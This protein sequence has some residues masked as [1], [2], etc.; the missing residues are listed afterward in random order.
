MSNFSRLLGLYIIILSFL[1]INAPNFFFIPSSALAKPLTS[2]SQECNL[3]QESF[4][5]EF[6]DYPIE[7]Q[8]WALLNISVKYR[9]K[10]TREIN[11]DIYPDF[12]PIAKR[13]EQFLVE[14]PNE[15]D[16][17]EV[18]NRNLAQM[19]LNE[20]SD[21]T[22]IRIYINVNHTLNERYTRH[23]EITLTRPGSCPLTHS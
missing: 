21:L 23:S 10:N 4:G 2:I 16:Y 13:I 7:H 8:G 20:Y 1:G 14:Y 17:W 9:L 11:P 19:L 5:F 15:T 12:V 22:S 18:V 3:H 6:S